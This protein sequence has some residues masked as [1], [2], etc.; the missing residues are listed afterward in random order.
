LLANGLRRLQAPVVP[1]FDNQ[2]APAQNAL[3]LSTHGTE[4]NPLTLDATPADI[5]APGLKGMQRTASSGDLGRMMMG[6]GKSSRQWLMPEGEREKKWLVE[7]VEKRFGTH[8]VQFFTTRTGFGVPLWGGGQVRK[9]RLRG[10]HQQKAAS[11]S[12]AAAAVHGPSGWWV[13]LV[14][15]SGLRIRVV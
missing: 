2:Q 3:L 4:K 13:S 9:E 11:A 12:N 10:G 6:G 15:N 5:L 8:G 14:V 7:A 1:R